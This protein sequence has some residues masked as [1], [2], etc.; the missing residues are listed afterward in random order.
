VFS[1]SLRSL[2][3]IVTLLCCYLGWELNV[4]RV[5]KVELARLRTTYTF[6]VAPARDLASQVPRGGAPLPVASVSLLRRLLGDQAIQ[7][8]EYFPHVAPPPAEIAR[9][10]RIFP[11][12]NIHEGHPPLE[13][14][15][16]GCFP[17][18]T[19]VE[20]PQGP[21]AIERLQPGD[22]ILAVRDGTTS[23]AAI[24]SIFTTTNRLWEIATADAVFCTTESQ[25]LC[26][27]DHRVV[28]GGQ[29]QAGDRLMRPADG[30]LI[31]LAVISVTRTDRIER[32]FN[33]ILSDAEYFLPAGIVARCKPP[34]EEA[35]SD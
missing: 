28:T 33:L 12:A 31:P 11:E 13:P 16:P 23:P 26:V 22:F 29:L 6:Q 25:P 34:T 19:L 27:A 10:R 20:T 18:G 4:V 15:H 30:K 14:C 17:A 5:R 7:E 8:I 32:V 1:F 3:V 2:L 21:I 24:E 35:R 9:F